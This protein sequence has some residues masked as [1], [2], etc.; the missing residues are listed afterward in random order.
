VNDARTVGSRRW[1]FGARVDLAVFVGPALIALVLVGLAPVLGVDRS[2]ET[3][4]WGWIVAVLLVDVAHVWST[5]FVT[6]LDPVELAARRTIY[7]AVPIGAFG[8]GVALYAA[9]PLVFWRALA[10]LAVFHFVRQQFGWVMMYRA[11]CGERD[12]LGRWLDGALIYA[13][14]LYPLIY[15]H[16]A[17]PRRFWWFIEGDFAPGV[18]AAVAT[19]AGWIYVALAIIYV[20]RAI[21]AARR[22]LVNVGKHLVVL[23]TAACWYVGIVALDGD[24]AFTITNVLIHGVPYLALIW[25]YGRGLTATDRASAAGLG[26]RWLAHGVV[27]F[28]ASLWAIAFVEELIWDRAV[29]HDRAW[30]FGAGGDLRS[31]QVAL[32]PLLAVPQITHYVL[33]GFLWRRAAN[34]RLGPALA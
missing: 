25:L 18:P 32:V 7:A 9:G 28:L 23:T 16:A 1:L 2:G 30:L 10:Y 33:D 14:T 20:V 17:L 5:I 12:R 29:W 24:F 27:A 3:P 31:W 15:W 26:G 4:E 11:R 19:V 21:G 6:Y 13:T 34:P 22:G 8:A